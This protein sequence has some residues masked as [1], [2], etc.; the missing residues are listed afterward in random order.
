MEVQSVKKLKS[1]DHS[2]R[3]CVVQWA[4]DRL[5]EDKHF[6]DDGNQ[7][8]CCIKK[9]CIEQRKSSTSDFL[10]QHLNPRQYCSAFL[11]KHE[12]G[13]CQCR[14]LLYHGQRLY[15][16]KYFR[17]LHGGFVVYVKLLYASQNHP[18]FACRV[19]KSLNI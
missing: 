17:V 9:I 4:D 2:T 7:N 6:G 16:S 14:S 3:V 15:L 1:L 5:I 12:R 13:C 11:R 8:F 18:Y 19:R 10:L